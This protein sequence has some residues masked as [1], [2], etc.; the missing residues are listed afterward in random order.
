M[1]S[2]TG[3]R[4][5]DTAEDAAFEAK[6]KKEKEEKKRFKV[7]KTRKLEEERLANEAA[8]RERAAA[9]ENDN[10]GR[11][12]K[13]RK[14][15]PTRYE[16]RDAERGNV[17]GGSAGDDGS[18]SQGKLLRFE[19][20]ARA[21]CRDVKSFDKLNDIEEGTY[22]YVSRAKEVK[23]GKI[24][25]L[26]RLKIEPGDQQGFPVT[27]MREIRILRNC[28]HRNIVGLQEIVTGQDASKMPM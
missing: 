2:K 23:T 19:S 7:E 14:L 3:S 16:S 10:G 20:P 28:N 18:S 27:A 13:R 5:A 25:A 9:S 6:R 22:G 11:P 17:E 1:S 26:K 24:V 8:E 4:W 21:A 12:A 15:T